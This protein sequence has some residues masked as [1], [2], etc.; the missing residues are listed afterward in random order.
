MAMKNTEIMALRAQLRV[1]QTQLQDK[2]R[3]LTAVRE[4]SASK[5][6]ELQLAREQIDRLLTSE[7]CPQ[8]SSAVEENSTQTDAMNRNNGWHAT[9]VDGNGEG[10][11]ELV[12]GEDD[13]DERSAQSAPL[14][15]P[16]TMAASEEAYVLSLERQVDA[17]RGRLQELEAQLETERL[18]W[19]EEKNKVIRYQKQLQLN[20]VQMQRKNTALEAEVEQL[21]L[22]LERR[23][24]KLTALSGEEESVC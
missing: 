14:L 9:D 6:E 5:S 2:D 10:E 22:E 3:A 20:Y 17:L 15:R 7:S 12:D 24:L 11:E 18:Q 13:G 16:A 23:D 8:E 4:E 1:L 21:T 19:L